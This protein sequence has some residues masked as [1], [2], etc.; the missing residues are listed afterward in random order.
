MKT[1]LKKKRGFTLVELLVVVAIL[2]V[3]ILLAIPTYSDSAKVSKIRTFESSFRS[4]MFSINSSLSDNGGATNHIAD[5]IEYILRSSAGKPIGATYVYD[6]STFTLT[7]TLPSINYG[8]SANYVL[9]YHAK[10]M[11]ITQSPNPLPFGA[12]NLAQN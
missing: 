5:D 2:G 8:G 9:T 10:T 7:A 6:P 11:Q 3:L 1:N 4:M 12:T